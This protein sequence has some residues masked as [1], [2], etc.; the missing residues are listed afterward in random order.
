MPKLLLKIPRADDDQPVRVDVPA[1]GVRDL[2][3][4]EGEDRL[5]L[6]GGER[7][8][9]VCVQVRND[10]RRYRPVR[11]AAD[12]LGFDERSFR[13]SDFLVCRALLEESL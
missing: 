13:V 10:L 9:A 8:C 6:V 4:S 12:F 3:W 11:G 2:R 7:E 5:F 1:E